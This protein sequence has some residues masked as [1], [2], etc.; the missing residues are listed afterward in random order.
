MSKAEF[1]K[2]LLF[3]RDG[4]S[5]EVFGPWGWRPVGG[6]TMQSLREMESD[7]EVEFIPA[8]DVAPHG[9]PRDAM[10]AFGIFLVPGITK[11]E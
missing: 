10:R 8:A 2:H 3:R 7:P 11:Q 5:F 1:G 6:S 9:A 4:D